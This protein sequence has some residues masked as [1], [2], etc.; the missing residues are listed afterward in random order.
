MF[1]PSVLADL[2]APYKVNERFIAPVIYIP[3]HAEP[4]MSPMRM[5]AAAEGRPAPG[6]QEDV[7]GWKGKKVRHVVKRGVFSGK[8]A[9][10][11]CVLLLPTPAA[12]ARLGTLPFAVKVSPGS[13][14]RR[15]MGM[16]RRADHFAP[17]VSFHRSCSSRRRTRTRQRASRRDRCRSISSSVPSSRLRD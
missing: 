7:A 5:I 2:H 4:E 6:P 15:A 14:G 16:G 12:F 3:R 8:K 10:Y 9:W 1:H 11:E 13:G 17:R